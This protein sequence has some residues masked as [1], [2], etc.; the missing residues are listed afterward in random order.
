MSSRSRVPR[1]AL[2]GG[3]A[4]L[5]ESRVY[6]PVAALRQGDEFSALLASG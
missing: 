2:T 4:F 1:L 6:G 3:E 5:G